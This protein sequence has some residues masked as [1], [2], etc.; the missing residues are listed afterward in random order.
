MGRLGRRIGAGLA[1]FWRASTLTG[2]AVRS[3]AREPVLGLL[4]WVA[5]SLE[6]AAVMMRRLSGSDA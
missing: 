2:A 3:S 5:C 1:V 6:L 4:D